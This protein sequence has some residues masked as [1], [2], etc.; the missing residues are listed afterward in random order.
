MNFKPSLIL[1]LVVLLLSQI[2]RFENVVRISSDG[3]SIVA[4]HF[5]T[6]LKLPIDISAVERVTIRFRK[7]MHGDAGLARLVVSAEGGSHFEK[8]W[9]TLWL[10]GREWFGSLAHG[11]WPKLEPSFNDWTAA[12]LWSSEQTII[13]SMPGIFQ[14]DATMVGRGS[15]EVTFHTN[16]GPIKISIADGAIDNSFGICTASGCPAVTE[17]VEP[18]SVNISRIVNVLCELLLPAALITF[19]GGFFRRNEDTQS[20]GI[21]GFR[22]GLVTLAFIHFGL[23]AF[24][25]IKILGG[26]PHIPDS[27][28]YY[29]QAILMTQG[30]LESAPLP[31]QPHEA[32]KS[33]ASVVVDGRLVHRH[34]NHFWPALIALFLA[35]GV[36][37]FVGPVLSTLG[38]VCFTTIVRRY[39]DSRTALLAG[40]FYAMSPFTIIQAGEFM[41]HTATLSLLLMT[42]LAWSKGVD[43]GRMGWFSLAG[44]LCSYAFSIRQLT[45][46]GVS[47]ALLC[48]A[49]FARRRP[50]P[51]RALA[52]FIVGAAP[53]LLFF[54]IDSKLITGSYLAS[55]HS[56]LWGLSVSYTNFPRGLGQM[57]SVLAGLLT[58]AFYTPW[59]FVFGSLVCLGIL[60]KPDRWS[61]LAAGTLIGLFSAYCFLN[62]NGMHGYGP[63]FMFEA[64]PAAFFLAARGVVHGLQLR[65]SAPRSIWAFATA[66]LFAINLLGLK[67]ILPSYRNYNGID[68]KIV[69]RLAQLPPQKSLVLVSEYGWQSM[70]MAAT[71][72]D[73]SFEGL[74][75]IK[76]LPDGRHNRLLEHFKDR[77]VYC[78]DGGLRECH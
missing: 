8:R 7:T 6:S 44:F 30:R 67:T 14:L 33:N 64:L 50:R 66:C 23:S 72:Y 56:Y 68:T 65:S 28:V 77:T 22:C 62:T 18:V 73:P 51:W 74:I 59:Y 69:A 47:A 45:V 26:V 10:W 2:T 43:S 21:W 11:V 29:R 42:L 16:Q 53:V 54:C 17:V 9:P 31:E 27:A 48:A 20:N 57:E 34:A 15:G 61:C 78:L 52:F 39:F 25:A 13:D 5:S 19:I 36:P 35:L 1:T 12:H 3:S 49:L 70:D 32:F 76:A 41:M 24:F 75:V 63:R 37:Q 71:L 40:S 46:V 55:P 38:L 4:E 60:A 58:I